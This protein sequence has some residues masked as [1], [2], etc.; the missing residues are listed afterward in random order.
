MNSKILNRCIKTLIISNELPYAVIR[1]HFAMEARV[2]VQF[3]VNSCG[4]FCGHL[5]FCRGFLRVL[6][7]SQLV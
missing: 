7:L 2:Q 1:L 5:V 4:I 3:K 6:W